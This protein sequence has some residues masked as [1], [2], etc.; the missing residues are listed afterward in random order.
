[1]SADYSAYAAKA[2]AVDTPELNMAL[3][4]KGVGAT[5]PDDGKL[6]IFVPQNGKVV[7]VQDRQLATDMV[8]YSWQDTVVYIQSGDVWKLRM[9]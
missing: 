8:L 9:K 6:T 7:E 3:L 1:M 4:P 5:I 2:E